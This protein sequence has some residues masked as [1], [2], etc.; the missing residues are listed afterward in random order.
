MTN[1]TPQACP[2]YQTCSAPICPLD[3][4]WKLRVLCN[5]DSTCFYLLESVKDA[6]KTHFQVAQ[7]GHMYDRICE[8]RDDICTTH[9]RLSKK[10]E[11]SKKSSSR[12]ARRFK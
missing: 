6:S 9:K 10:V 2:K 5:E 8:V 11:A 4:N 12:M 3:K 7:L 1:I